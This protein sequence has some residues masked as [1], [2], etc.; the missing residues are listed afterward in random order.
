MSSGP[1]YPNICLK[2]TEF[3]PLNQE[4]LA[5]NLVAP[6]EDGEEKC[7]KFIPSYAPPLGLDDIGTKDLRCLC[8]KHIKFIIER[9]RDIG[10]A[11]QG[12]I[13]IISWKVFEAVNRYRRLNGA[14]GNVSCSICALMIH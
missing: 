6:K 11:D 3:R 1:N 14:N 4:T 5:L 12:D 7:F 8:K 13:S 10:E 2:V 9:E